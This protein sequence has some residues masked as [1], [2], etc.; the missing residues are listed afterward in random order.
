MVGRL[1]APVRPPGQ[2]I[3]AVI[4][5]TIVIVIVVVVIIIVIAGGSA[6]INRSLWQ[7]ERSDQVTSE[8]SATAQ[9]LCEPLEV[10]LLIQRVDKGMND[11]INGRGKT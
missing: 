5:V 8:E 9:L 2:L 10:S 6:G 4:L 7:S 1:Q 11:T 3:T